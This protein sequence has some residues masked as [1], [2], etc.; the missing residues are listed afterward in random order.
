MIEYVGGPCGWDRIAPTRLRQMACGELSTWQNYSTSRLLDWSNPRIIHRS[1]FSDLEDGFDIQ[2][3]LLSDKLTERWQQT[4]LRFAACGDLTDM[5]FQQVLERSLGLIRR[6]DPIF[7]T[8]SGM[9]RSLHVLRASGWGFDCSYSDPFLPFSI[10]VSCPMSTEVHRAERLAENIVHEAL[11]LQLSLVERIEPL[12]VECQGASDVYSPWKD[13]RRPVQGVLHGVY[14]YGNLSY[15][16]NCI[17]AQFSVYS[18]FAEARVEEIDNELHS[19]K[20][21]ANH[22]SLTWIG[23]SILTSLLCEL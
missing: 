6:V 3:E 10:F 7:G 15:F 1:A 20:G 23:R 16:W 18:S 2:V 21:L 13:E 22:P 5:N 4:G 11:H 12:I 14:V 17:G 9:C 8:V 19:L